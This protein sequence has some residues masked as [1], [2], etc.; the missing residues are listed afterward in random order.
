[1]HGHLQSG[2]SINLHITQASIILDKQ[3]Q[4]YYTHKVNQTTDVKLQ[5][6]LGFTSFTQ[7]SSQK[8]L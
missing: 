5:N 2:G 4:K 3:C 1:M 8:H 6:S 7:R